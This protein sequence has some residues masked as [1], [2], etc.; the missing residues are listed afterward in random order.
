MAVQAL[1]K[2]KGAGILNGHC[3]SPC[4]FFMDEKPGI[5]RFTPRS[6]SKSAMLIAVAVAVG[7]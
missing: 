1:V 5:V 4:P 7:V 6:T 3:P 2:G